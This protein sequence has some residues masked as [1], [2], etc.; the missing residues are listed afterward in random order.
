M[1]L[2]VAIELPNQ[3]CGQL[4]KIQESLWPVVKGRWTRSEQMHLTLKFLGETPDGDLPKVIGELARVRAEC[5]IRLSAAGVVCFPPNG[6]IRIVAA[7]LKDNGD[8]C[9]KLQG[10]I[11]RACHTAGFPLE[12]RRWR[13][14]VT[15]ARVKDRL[16]AS[17]RA[18]A[19][20]VELGEFEFVADGFSLIESRLDRSGPNY[21]RIAAFP[22][23][24]R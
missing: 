17:V 15:L 9:A 16:P 19:I 23:E 7:E 12:G 14:H 11:D 6:P 18:A 24:G 4:Q 13:P 5:E 2:F 1:R 3:V 22:I 20:A 10:E 8:R 21:A